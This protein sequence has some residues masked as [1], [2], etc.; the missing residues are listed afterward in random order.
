MLERKY[1]GS[2]R[3]RRAART[4]QR[5]FRQ[6]C[7]NKNFQKLRHS[8]GERRLSKRL[9]ELGRSNTVWTDRL[10]ADFTDTNGNSAGFP[11]PPLL[12]VNAQQQ[13]QQQL[14]G[15]SP[16]FGR[17]IRRMV[18]DFESSRRSPERS[19][20]SG[21]GNLSGGQ[22]NRSSSLN[23][24][25]GVGVDH[26]HQ[27]HQ[28]RTSSL[29]LQRDSQR[30]RLER[31]HHVGESSLD[32]QNAG[33]HPGHSG[34]FPG[35]LS[36]NAFSSPGFNLEGTSSQN[37]NSRGN[38]AN[39]VNRYAKSGGSGS[40]SGLNSGSSPAGA[41]ATYS[42]G[43]VDGHLGSSYTD[44]SVVGSG[45][46]FMRTSTL[47]N[48]GT[49][50]DPHSVNFET[51]L[52]SKETD[53]LT[54]SFHSEASGTDIMGHHHH[55]IHQQLIHQQNRQSAT[56]VSNINNNNN[57][58]IFNNIIN[59]NNSNNSFGLDSSR[60]SSSPGS[61]DSF[62][63]MSNDPSD[64]LQ[65]SGNSSSL[66]YGPDGGGGG[67][68]G[69]GG[70]QLRRGVPV[71]VKVEMAPSPNVSGRGDDQEEDE[72][73]PAYSKEQIEMAVQSQMKYY[74]SGAQIKYRSGS[75]SSTGSLSAANN[76]NRQTHQL[77]G[78]L[79]NNNSSP[80][81]LSS[82]AP[83]V[84]IVTPTRMSTTDTSPIWKRKGETPSPA[85]GNNSVMSTP[86]PGGQSL[87]SGGGG[88]PALGGQHKGVVD[89]KRMS[90]ISETSEPDSVGD[91][92]NNSSSQSSENVSTE[93][94]S[95]TSNDP[96]STQ[97]SS[98][99]LNHHQRKLRMRMSSSDGSSSGSVSGMPRLND[100]QRKRLYRIGLNLFN[101]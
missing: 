69:G 4:I 6:Y 68:E 14:D 40:G 96:L 75:S 95:V 63:P 36:R 37:Y 84:A 71:Q 53:I 88:T 57:V 12:P 72:S 11:P 31:G 89:S 5:A 26:Q 92:V 80:S 67:G 24:D 76:N 82:P 52:E 98:M 48:S 13:Q 55:N 38:S 83:N 62:R 21:G 23:F 78:N 39:N 59:N 47:E 49:S 86:S 70:S 45:G 43:G 41:G 27:H 93:N 19:S 101:K 94:I 74:M 17:D 10:S 33:G 16:A 1:G 79:S 3:S 46:E 20:G 42:G 54:D 73:I 25:P 2:I 34:N 66:D 22:Q 87:S 97:T 30:R 29:P 100:K 15:G 58:A 7:M 99:S 9:S 51:L 85:I 32:R 91:W 81:P 18:S 65:G 35:K 60:L 77:G 90:N 61:V 8:Y 64:F 56:P 44:V 50:A 28:Y